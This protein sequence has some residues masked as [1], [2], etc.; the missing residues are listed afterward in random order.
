M[1]E[2]TLQSIV[3]EHQ[4][5]NLD[6]AKAIGEGLDMTAGG[7]VTKAEEHLEADTAPW[8]ERAVASIHRRVSARTGAISYQVRYRTPEGAAKSETF[9]LK[10][11]A[12]H[13]ARTVEIAKHSG[14]WVDP[15]LAELPAGDWATRWLA[16]KTNLKPSTL[17][18]YGD[19]VR[20][21][22][23]PRW[24]RTRLADIRHEDVQDWLADMTRAPA[25]IRKT[26]RVWSQIL[27]YAV[28]SGRLTANPARGVTLPT[29]EPPE[30][31][32]LTH[33]QVEA[34]ATE[35]GPAWRLLVLLLAYTGLRWGEVAAL[36]VSRLDLLR[37]R[38]VVAESVTPVDG[39]M[40]WGTPK[41]RKT[42]EVPIPAFLARELERHIAAREL[43]PTSLV[44]T[45]ARGAVLR[46]STFRS[47]V[48]TPAAEELGLCEPKLDDDGQP[49]VRRRR[50]AEGGWIE[51]PV[52]TRHLHPHEFRHTAASLAIASGADVK[53]VQQMLGHKSATMTLDLYG[54]LFPDRLDAVADALELARKDALSAAG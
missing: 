45:G 15:K 3:H 7:L 35:A 9:K 20:A 50:T 33:A 16:T 27:D 2:R 32:Y 11:D 36:K 34:L 49:V 22:I 46:A 48:L 47:A 17:E 23:Q 43:G 6:Q 18:R 52:Y 31:R 8:P 42:R 5:V 21:D 37:R 4:A 30:K 40:T 29:V 12:A 26:H 19:I 24:G 38:I 51:V 53:V 41:G 28:R 10:R 14:G 44:F 39:V 1:S 54:H 13:F 25:T